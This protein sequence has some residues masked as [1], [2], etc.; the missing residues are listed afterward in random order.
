MLNWLSSG[1]VICHYSRNRPKWQMNH[2]FQTLKKNQSKT[3]DN[4]SSRR[5]RNKSKSIIWMNLIDIH[6]NKEPCIVVQLNL[7]F[8]TPCDEE[9]NIPSYSCLYFD[10][11][12]DKMLLPYPQ[13]FDQQWNQTQYFNIFHHRKAIRS[14]HISCK[15]QYFYHSS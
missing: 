8:C 14:N 6:I 10:Y 3:K 11:S 15:G 4:G 13:T 1:N 5:Y 2:L 12:R 9:I 7:L